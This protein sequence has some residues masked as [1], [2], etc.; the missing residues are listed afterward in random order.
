M[1]S[2]SIPAF[3]HTSEPEKGHPMAQCHGSIKVVQH[4]S[5]K[6][7]TVNLIFTAFRY[8]TGY[9]PMNTNMLNFKKYS[10][11]ISLI[12]DSRFYLFK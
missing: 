9:I 5:Q 10:I 12:S 2:P 8:K 7:T 4:E 1:N 11:Q 6:R 3:Q